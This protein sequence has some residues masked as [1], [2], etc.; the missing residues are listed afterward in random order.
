MEKSKSLS[1]KLVIALVLYLIL[2][3]IATFAL[4]GVLR[5]VMWI[6]F[7]GLAIKTVIASNDDRTMD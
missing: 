2:G 5:T 3:L 7:L 6:F 4:D 1:V